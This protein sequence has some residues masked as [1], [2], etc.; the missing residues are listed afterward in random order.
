MHVISIPFSISTSNEDV[1]HNCLFFFPIFI[2]FFTHLNFLRSNFN[3]A[4]TTWYYLPLLILVFDMVDEI[5]I[6]NTWLKRKTK[7]P[8]IEVLLF[9]ERF[10]EYLEELEC[11]RWGD[12]L[13]S[14]VLVFLNH[15]S[16]IEHFGK[17]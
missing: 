10:V 11:L 1:W 17:M 5:A 8:L 16:W 4:K 9:D 13:P 2:S 15:Q 7:S 14:H 6:K 12:W 3:Y